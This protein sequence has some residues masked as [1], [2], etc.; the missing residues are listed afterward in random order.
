[1]KTTMSTITLTHQLLFAA[2]VLS[3]YAQAIQAMAEAGICT[4][5]VQA[6]LDVET[7]AQF[8]QDIRKATLSVGG[9]YHES[10][11]I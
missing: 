10:Y 4:P 7:K 1:M 5:S 11:G 3:T 9:H 6:Q 2:R 8:C